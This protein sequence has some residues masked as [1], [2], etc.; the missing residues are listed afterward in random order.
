MCMYIYIY[1]Y[2]CIHIYTIPSAR[3]AALLAVAGL[4]AWAGL[5]G[6]LSAQLHYIQLLLYKTGAP[7]RFR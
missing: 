5:G 2:T 6:A 7:G 4:A 3:G 1:I